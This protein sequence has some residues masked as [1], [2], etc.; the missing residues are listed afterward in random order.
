[1]MNLIYLLRN[2]FLA[3]FLPKQGSP[4][5]LNI[6]YQ[7]LNWIGYILKPNVAKALLIIDTNLFIVGVLEIK[8]CLNSI[9]L[10]I[11]HISSWSNFSY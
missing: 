1:M 10:I 11:V 7:K 4:L 8:S 5:F 6:K 3:S 2:K 9:L